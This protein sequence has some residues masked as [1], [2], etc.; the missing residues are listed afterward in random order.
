MLKCDF[1]NAN[2]RWLVFLVCKVWQRKSSR[3]NLSSIKLAILA[4]L[5]S[6][7]HG[8]YN[9]S[10]YQNLVLVEISYAYL[11]LIILQNMGRMYK[12]KCES[13]IT[14]I[15]FLKIRTFQNEGIFPQIQPKWPN[16]PLFLQIKI[17]RGSRMSRWLVQITYLQEEKHLHRS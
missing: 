7:F 8:V 2:L 3:K 16:N 12:H 1:T 4:D 13:C 10:N 6:Q 17:I 11:V 9:S 15:Y 14:P 5:W